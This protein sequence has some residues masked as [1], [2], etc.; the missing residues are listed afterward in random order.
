MEIIVF[1]CCKHDGL[2]IFR[3]GEFAHGCAWA[4]HRSPNMENP[5][6]SAISVQ[7]SL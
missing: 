2:N 5:A 3:L 6:G 4:R 7:L 1:V